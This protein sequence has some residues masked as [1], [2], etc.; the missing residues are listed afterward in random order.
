MKTAVIS[1]LFLFLIS[2]AVT[3][4]QNRDRHLDHRDDFEMESISGGDF[5][6]YIQNNIPENDSWAVSMQTLGNFHNHMHEM[7]THI[8]RHGSIE[9]GEEDIPDFDLRI[10]GGEWTEIRKGL[11]AEGDRSEWREL[12]QIT[13]IMHDR[14]HH[15]MAKSLLYDHGINNRTA[16]P[17]DYLRTEPMDPSVAIPDPANLTYSHISQNEF[18]EF[19]WD[20]ST[21]EEHKH[22]AFQA[23]AIFN[24]MLYDLL[25]QWHNIGYEHTDS[26]CRPANEV[27]RV[28][29]SDWTAYASQIS[30]C[31]DDTWM[32]LIKIS[33]LM[34]N[35]IHH[36]MYKMTAL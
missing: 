29:S 28:T 20:L 27:P 34:K 6:T 35:R 18:R 13:E 33:E 2:D 32:E 1:V 22:A 10:S 30:G 23:M 7:M 5:R 16:D 12:I 9:R 21:D 14:V 36:M 19:V 17:S 24:H 26:E 11:E 31:S 25:T 3:G 4:Q 8:A 15:V